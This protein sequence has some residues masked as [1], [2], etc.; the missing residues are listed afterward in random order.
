[1]FYAR[2]FD[3]AK[4]IFQFGL[5]VKTAF[6]KNRKDLIKISATTATGASSVKILRSKR[7]RANRKLIRRF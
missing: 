3:A 4:N 6:I 2:F 5:S 1:M 7:L